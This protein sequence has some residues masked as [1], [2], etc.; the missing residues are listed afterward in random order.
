MALAVK[1][2]P[3]TISLSQIRSKFSFVGWDNTS[4]IECNLKTSLLYYF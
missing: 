1:L 3:L 4:P 2:Y